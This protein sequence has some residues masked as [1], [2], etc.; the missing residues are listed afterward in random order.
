MSWVMLKV[1]AKL[2]TK[3]L[4]AIVT[5]FYLTLK[6]S[7]R[8][9]STWYSNRFL[10]YRGIAIIGG[11]EF[12]PEIGE[13]VKGLIN[14]YEFRYTFV[15]DP[16]QALN[17]EMEALTKLYL[18]NLTPEEMTQLKKVKDILS[19]LPNPDLHTSINLIRAN[20]GRLFL[21]KKQ[22][23]PNLFTVFFYVMTA[24]EAKFLRNRGYYLL[25]LQST[26]PAYLTKF[27]YG[28][29]FGALR[30]DRYIFPDGDKGKLMSELET[31]FKDILEGRLHK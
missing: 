5:L 14:K 13:I 25:Y 26:N 10:K 22:F 23:I 7:F 6:K 2:V 27:E 28:I 3:S 1:L 31:L 18:P 4:A 29:T 15:S 16:I 8:Y 17:N 24:D 9:I 21:L 19:T 30:F 20:L 11:L 12:R